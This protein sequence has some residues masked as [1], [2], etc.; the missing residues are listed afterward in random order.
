LPVLYSRSLTYN[1]RSI[2]D[3]L[4]LV[5]GF[6]IVLLMSVEP[7]V[8]T[9]M[10]SSQSML[11]AIYLFIAGIITAIALV[12]PGISGSFMLLALGLYDVTLK[13]INSLNIPLLIPL[14]L[15]IG[16]GTL[17]TTKLIEKLLQKY[18]RKTYMLI[19]GFVAGSLISVYPGMPPSFCCCIC[20]R[21]HFYILVGKKGLYRLII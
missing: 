19:I 18:P 13:A 10:A 15:G 4:I 1:K 2:M 7:T 11:S 6:A 14:L 3:Y 21:F 5:F 12:L 9:A 20:Y 16:A 17:G 8:S